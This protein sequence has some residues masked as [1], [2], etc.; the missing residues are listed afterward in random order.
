M[1]N[2][3]F[4]TSTTTRPVVVTATEPVT[5]PKF[6][7]AVYGGTV[8]FAKVRSSD[9]LRAWPV[10]APN[11]PERQ[12]AEQVMKARA[13]KQPVEAIAKSMNVS[14]PTVRRL[15]T[16]YTFTLEVEG[17]KAAERSALA[18]SLTEAAKAAPKEEKKPAA[19]PA[20]KSE[21]KKAAPAK[22]KASKPAKE[23]NTERLARMKEEGKVAEKSTTEN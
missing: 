11:S 10:L 19:K 3:T 8:R 15:I 12:K 14:V 17:M 23:S 6:L 9:T 20:P 4:T 21:E 5:G 7:E 1:S 13:A 2:T 22:P 16:A 18:K